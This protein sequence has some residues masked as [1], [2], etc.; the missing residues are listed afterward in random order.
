MLGLI[1]FLGIHLT[2]VLAPAWREGLIASRGEAVWKGAYTA[3]SLIGFA[4]II[5]GYGMARR[6]AAVLWVAPALIKQL[7]IALNLL[8][9][10][11][12]AAAY[13]PR[14]HIKSAIGHPMVAGTK[15][16]ALAHLISN[17]R[18]P[19]LILFGSFLLW[20][21]VLFA[22]SRRR[23]RAQGVTYAKGETAQTIMTLIAGAV[24]WAAF[25]YWLHALLIGIA[26]LH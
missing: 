20:S 19:A 1:I 10:I 3:I 17:G 22:A 15:T 16:W 13:V 18:L 4:L 6:D 25:T 11:L 12:L 24:A 5:W 8:A 9:F 7:A 14:N 26:P 21:V 23:D 2:R